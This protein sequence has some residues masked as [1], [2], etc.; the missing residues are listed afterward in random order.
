MNRH[1]QFPPA[2]APGIITQALQLFTLGRFPEA[3]ALLNLA[4]RSVRDGDYFRLRGLILAHLDELEDALACFRKAVAIAPGNPANHLNLADHCRRLGR[5][6]LAVQHY[7][8][9]LDLSPS[10]RHASLALAEL[11]V[12][13]GEIA[14]RHQARN[15]AR[16]RPDVMFSIA[17]ALYENGAQDDAIRLLEDTVA[18]AP[19]WVEPRIFLGKWKTDRVKVWHFQMMRDD[20]RNRAYEQALRQAVT[21]DSHVLEIGTG[22]GLLS[23]M[24]ARAGAARVT[25]CEAIGI[26]AETAAAIVRDNG[27]TDRISVVAKPSNNLRLGDD[28]PAKADILVAEIIGDELL[29]EGVLAA[30]L[31]ARQRLLKPDARLI[32]YRIASVVMLVGGKDLEQ[33]ISVE[34]QEGFDLSA[35]NRFV[36]LSMSLT[37]RGLNLH[38]L[39]AKQTAF[40]FDLRADGFAP[41]ERTMEFSVTEAGRCVGVLQWIRLHLDEN[42][43]FENAPT[44]E[45]LPS[46]WRPVLFPFPRPL[47]VVAGQAI[48]VLA[49]HNVIS[50]VFL[51]AS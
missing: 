50:Q 3:K 11:L 18:Q 21:P 48:T 15:F 23:M 36:P 46:G 20:G 45:F 40:D 2:A 12:R 41:Q 39:S 51:L 29:A 44:N 14:T 35:F 19:A 24:A 6:P 33:L 43:A 32:P 9:A 8:K 49:K 13:T 37:A 17:N 25:T 16:E 7:R 34:R 38:H 10:D 31:D 47:D 28:L 1:A 22:S 4:E 26:I 30:T 42:T 5:V 27:L